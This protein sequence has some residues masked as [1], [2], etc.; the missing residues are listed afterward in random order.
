MAWGNGDDD[1]LQDVDPEV[2]A[3]A[4]KL[5]E[6][7]G[8]AGDSESEIPDLP[9]ALED[10]VEKAPIW[11]IT[12]GDVT[13]LMLAFFVMLYSMSYLQSEKW[14]EVISI[15]ATRLQPEAEGQPKPSADRSMTRVEFVP[16]F[17]TGYLERILDQKLAADPILSNVRLTGLDDILVLS[18]QADTLFSQEGEA[19]LKDEAQELLRRLYTVF[20]QFGNRIDV[21]S[22][23]GP[24]P[25]SSSS[26]YADNWSLSL[27]RGLVVAQRLKALGYPG[28]LTVM[29]LGDSRYQNIDTAIP[30]SRRFE[31]SQRV[32]FVISS[33]AGGQ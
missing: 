5:A 24:N 16:A 2:A 14:D 9:D 31:L 23:T 25:P 28:N 17:S 27:G 29:G 13:A 32:D 26:S 7:N 11:L 10:V 15:L 20:I 22:H 21:H 12:F 30:E 19:A 1:D 18:V 3:Y 8:Q 33:E 6:L 4:Q